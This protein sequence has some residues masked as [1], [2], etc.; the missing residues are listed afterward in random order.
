MEAITS[1]LTNGLQSAGTSAMSVIGSVLPYALPILA[2][3]IAIVL[4]IRYF[5]KAA[6]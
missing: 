6:K 5:K 4:G 1:G 3:G 2:A